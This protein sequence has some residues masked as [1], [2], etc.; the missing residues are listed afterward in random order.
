M[1]DLPVEECHLASLLMAIPLQIAPMPNMP[2]F[3]NT[4]VSNGHCLF[5]HDSRKSS[6]Q[7][8]NR[9]REDSALNESQHIGYNG[10][11][12][13]GQDSFRPTG[14]FPNRGIWLVQTS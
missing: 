12:S 5:F 2:P 10:L 13:S 3:S 8:S 1:H 9:G 11:V 7:G 6:Q 4:G 14:L